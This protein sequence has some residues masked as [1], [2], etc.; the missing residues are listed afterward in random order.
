MGLRVDCDIMG[1]ALTPRGCRT[2]QASAAKAYR[3][4]SKG[5]NIVDISGK[6]LNKLAMCCRCDK[7]SEEFNAQFVIDVVKA[8]WRKLI[9]YLES[10]DQGEPIEQPEPYS[11]PSSSKLRGLELFELQNKDYAI[12]LAGELIEAKREVTEEEEEGRD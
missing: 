2:N 7:C 11:L 9:T 3:A 4:L 1:A 8:E 6:N 10:D 5:T 12:E